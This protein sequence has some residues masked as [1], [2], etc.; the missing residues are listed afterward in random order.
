MQAKW[1]ALSC[2]CLGLATLPVNYQ[3]LHE[4]SYSLAKSG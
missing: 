3:T 4:A 1:C 2:G